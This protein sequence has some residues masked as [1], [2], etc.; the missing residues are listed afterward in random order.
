MP[1]KKTT[2]KTTKTD[3]A[4]KVALGAG[5]AAAAAAGY[6]LFGPKGTQ[7]RKKVKAWSLKAK[8]EVLEKI[9]GLESVAEEKY[10]DIVDKVAAKYAKKSDIANEEIAQ[11]A[12]EMRKYWKKIEKDV[13]PKKKK[14]P[15]KKTT[16]K[17]K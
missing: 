17:K 13:A 4:G 8:A 1:T 11:L 3:S 16:S 14:A 6:F 15:A 5:L 7:N 12:S 10:Y 9:E 2:K